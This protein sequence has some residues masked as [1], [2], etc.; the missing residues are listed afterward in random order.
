MVDIPSKLLKQLRPRPGSAVD[1]TVEDG[2]LV[3]R[4]AR[5]GNPALDRTPSKPP[6]WERPDR[7]A[8]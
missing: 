4:P 8:I 5:C 1:I 7:V 3:L 2:K 6:A